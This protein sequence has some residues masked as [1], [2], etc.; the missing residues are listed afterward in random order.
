MAEQVVLRPDRRIAVGQ[1]DARAGF[2][3]GFGSGAVEVSLYRHAT[4]ITTP[5]SVPCMSEPAVEPTADP[6]DDSGVWSVFGIASAV[7]GVLAV[8]ALVLTAV[9]WSGHRAAA[10][11]RDYEG[12]AMQAAADWT[13]VLINMNAG[14]VENSLQ[15]LRDGT[16]GEL[17]TGFE[18]SI[19]PY[20]DVVKTLQSRTIGEIE[21]VSVEALRNNLDI[22]PGQRPPA[23]SAV[24]AEM[25]SRNCIVLV[26]ATSVSENAGSKPTTVRW[27]LRLG[28]SE[29][30]GTPR[31]S[32]LESVR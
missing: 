8:A 14:N 5:G 1:I 6:Q 21:S 3:G 13:G 20:R 32:R 15:R 7:L 27:N 11:Q 18:A 16:V 9:L 26:V 22:R 12:R 4:I 23:P 19:A 17:N 29:V 31:I 10:G 30:D 28:V 24:P 2:G 25:A